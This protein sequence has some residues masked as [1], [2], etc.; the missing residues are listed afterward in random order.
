MILIILE[1]R[2]IPFKS[3][4][5]YQ[6]R[7]F[8]PLYQELDKAKYEIKK[9]YADALLDCAVSVSITFF[10]KIPVSFSKK[11]REK[12]LKGEIFPVTR[13]DRG[14]CLKFYEDTL[15]GTV[16]TDDSIIVDGPVRKRYA[17]KDST[18][19]QIERMNT[20]QVM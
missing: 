1:G 5:V 12:A 16:I 17:L 6:T 4:R 3:A 2:P 9:Q 10:F 14:N 8:N 20:D 13:P 15:I 19:I 7:T 18:V 11:K